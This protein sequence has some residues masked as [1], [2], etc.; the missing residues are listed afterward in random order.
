MTKTDKP[1]VI[2]TEPYAIINISFIVLILLIF[3][4]SAIFHQNNFDYPIHSQVSGNTV[5]TGL[6][7][8]FSEIVRCNLHKA[9][10]LNKYSLSIFMFFAVQLFIRIIVLILLLSTKKNRNLLIIADILITVLLFL[11]SFREFILNQF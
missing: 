5:S 1:L 3:I 8:A 11:Q 4:Y 6:S 10:K 9:K 7:R 2:K